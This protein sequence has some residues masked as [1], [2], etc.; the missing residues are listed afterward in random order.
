[1]GL[2]SLA[3]VI[4]ISAPAMTLT[5]NPAAAKV[6]FVFSTTRWIAGA[7]L[8]YL[9]FTCGVAT[10]VWMPVAAAARASAIDLSMVWGPSSRPAST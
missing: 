7:S 2:R 9:E 10:I 6:A 1:M 5:A 4:A 3:D 8:R